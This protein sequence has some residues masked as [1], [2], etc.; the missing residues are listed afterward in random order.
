M[1]SK[2]YTVLNLIFVGIILTIFIYSAL[3]ISA[4]VDHP[5]K[6]VHE[7]L[8][9]GPCPT[10]GI[11]RGFSAIMHGQFA[12][13]QK[14]QHN[15]INV[16]LFFILQLIFRLLFILITKRGSF[17]LSKLINADIVISFLLFF[18]FFRHLII[19]TL[20]IFYK[21]LLTGITD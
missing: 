3:F 4:G 1:N 2:N 8:L 14:I 12:L 20:Y 5:I 18:W 21:M 17:A 16:F 13:A 7:E 6:C 15:T 19:Q 10:C 11:S 9:G